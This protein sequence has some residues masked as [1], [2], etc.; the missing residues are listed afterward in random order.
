MRRIIYPFI[1]NKPIQGSIVIRGWHAI[2][3]AMSFRLLAN[4]AHVFPAALNPAG[5]IDRL[6]QL[7]DACKIDQAVCFAPFSHQCDGKDIIPNVWLANEIKKH[8]D[9]LLGFG[10]IDVRRADVAAQSAMVM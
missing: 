3:A 7:L 4:H 5:T 6:L 1:L 8:S 2:F 9:R 10:T